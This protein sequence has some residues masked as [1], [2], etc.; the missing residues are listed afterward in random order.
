[1][2]QENPRGV[3]KNSLLNNGLSVQECYFEKVGETLNLIKIRTD[4]AYDCPRPS[5]AGRMLAK[6][7]T[8]H[9]LF[10]YRSCHAS[11]LSHECV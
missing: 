9:V 10:P 7:S 5:R 11:I 8:R 4:K 2:P 6:P 3:R 1:M